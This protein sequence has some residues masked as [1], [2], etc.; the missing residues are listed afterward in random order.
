MRRSF[1][2]AAAA[3]A[4]ALVLP[5]ASTQATTPADVS[6]VVP[7]TF[8]PAGGPTLGP[9]TAS[10]PAVDAGLVCPAG[11]TIDVGAM[12]SGFRSRTGV[13]F[14]VVKLF[15]CGDGTGSFLVKLEV[16]IDRRGDNFNWV[17]LDGEGAY[18]TLRGTGVGTG[19]PIPGGVLDAYDGEVH[20]N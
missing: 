17:I 20:L 9:F 7:T 3:A 13:N 11:D 18:E 15:T 19:T 5:L 16:R 1:R 8:P 2:L 12:A 14:H 4:L 6:F 10:G